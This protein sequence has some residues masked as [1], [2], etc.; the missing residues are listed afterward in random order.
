MHYLDGSGGYA[1]VSSIDMVHWRWHPPLR[2]PHGM[3]S[4]GC[5]LSKEGVPV[6]IY[7]G[8]APARNYLAVGWTRR[9]R[10]GPRPIRSSRGSVRIRTAA[11]SVLG[12]DGW[13]EGDTYYAIFGGHPNQLKPATLMKSRDLKQWDYVGPFDQGHAGRGA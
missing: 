10:R 12:P 5:F 7:S 2:M 9:W 8:R 6:L 3:N 4:G 13:L 11:R 1:H